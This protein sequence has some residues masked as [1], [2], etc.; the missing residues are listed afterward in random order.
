MVIKCPNCNHYIS[1]TVTICPHCGNELSSLSSE[2]TE[3]NQSNSTL[4]SNVNTNNQ[5]PLEEREDFYED[6]EDSAGILMKIICFLIPIVGLVLYFVKRN[7]LPNA[8]KSYL[9]WAAA[10]F[11]FTL[12]VNLAL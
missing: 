9:I 5:T 8:A 3:S 12:L 10:G 1:D 4:V 2:P 6:V 11:G 7:N